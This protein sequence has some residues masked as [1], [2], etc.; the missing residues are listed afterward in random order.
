MGWDAFGLPAEN[1]A[2]Q[3]GVSPRTWTTRLE[4]YIIS[5]ETQGEVF[6]CDF[7]IYYPS[8][9]PSFPP[10]SQKQCSNIAAMKKQLF[11]MGL[12][13]DWDKEIST[14]DAS[15]YRWTQV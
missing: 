13:F 10:H 9:N 4:A 12:S 15:Y 6:A 3:R 14:C 1:A 2:V 7:S 11:S 8:P 5:F